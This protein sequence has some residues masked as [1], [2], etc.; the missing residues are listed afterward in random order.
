MSAAATSFQGR[1]RGL[2]LLSAQALAGTLTVLAAFGACAASGEFGLLPAG[3]FLLGLALSGP[4]GARVAHRF[5]VAWTTLLAAALILIG[6]QVAGGNVDIVLGAAWFALLLT[7]HRLWNR[8]TERD[9]LLLLLLS[10]LLLCAGAALS[11]ELLFGFAFVAYAVAGTWSLALT[12]LRFRLEAAKGPEAE[13]LLRSRRLVSPQLLAAL[14]GL[15]LLGL[16]GATA[17]FFIFPRV[18]LGGLRRASR[19]TPTVGLSERVELSGHG[20]LGDD[21]R[22]VLRVRLEPDPGTPELSLHW[23]ARALEVWTGQGWRARTQIRTPASPG[24]VPALLRGHR[25][26]FSAELEAV[27]GFSDGIVLTPEGWPTGVRFERPLTARPAPQRLLADA[28][29]DFFYQPV[30]IGDLRY[31]VSALTLAAGAEGIRSSG[32]L[33]EKLPALAALNLEVPPDLDPRVRALAVRLTKDRTPAAAAEA[34]RS[35]LESSFTYTRELAGDQKDPIAHFLFERKKGHCEL[36][37]SALVL[38]LRSAGVPARN[39]TGFYGGVRTAGGYY[40]VR[41]G[42][43]HSWAEAW[44]P[45]LGFVPFDPTP[46]SDRGSHQEGLWAS[47]VLAWDGLAARWRG[48]IVDFD[49]VSQGRALQGVASLL[50]EAT[51]R[52]SGRGGPGAPSLTGVW[53]LLAFAAGAV[54]LVTFARRALR[55][56]GRSAKATLSPD[57]ERARWLLRKARRR[58]ARAGLALTSGTSPRELAGLVQKQ[59]PRASPA[60]ERIVACWSACRWGD[61]KLERAGVT[62]LLRALDQAVRAPEPAGSSPQ[63]GPGPSTP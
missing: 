55:G 28:S 17:V 23:R 5:D 18:T 14:G 60:T 27:A 45:G 57:Q 29:G 2:T 50:R 20:V 12:H 41:A 22:V 11:A 10:L 4:L 9:E 36:F 46:A 6:L 62:G 1:T 15:S 59:L 13:L 40:A 25:A 31:V 7:Q 58:L 8:Q 35:Y 49:L 24:P 43:A 52:L 30:E 34:V 19:A 21:P 61:A 16:L 56:L 48:L 47:A 39:V 63:G 38:L 37:S 51:R 26:W 44:V 53:R 42:D 33:P 54:A 32:A 3:G